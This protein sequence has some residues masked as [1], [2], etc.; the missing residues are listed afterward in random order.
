MVRDCVINDIGVSLGM[1]LQWSL[2]TALLYNSLIQR[3]YVV[4]R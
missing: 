2:N 3:S 1:E 4:V